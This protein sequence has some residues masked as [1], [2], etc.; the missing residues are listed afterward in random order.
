MHGIERKHREHLKEELIK[1][2]RLD[3]FDEEEIAEVFRD[4]ESLDKTIS[5]KTLALCQTLSHASSSLV[6]KTLKRIKNASRFLSLREMDRWITHAFDLL[7]HQGVE[8]FISFISRMDEETLW[9]F[10]MPKGLSLQEV[11]PVLETYLRGISGR[12]LKI[13]PDKESYTDTATLY[14]PHF[15]AKYDERD[16]N[17]LLYKLM[18]AFQWAQISL[19]TLTPDAET[20]RTFLKDS[21]LN[22]PDIETFFRQFPDKELAVDLYTIIEAV[23]LEPLLEKELPGLMREAYGLKRDFL[24]E[25]ISLFD[26]SEKAAFVEGLYQFYLKGDAGDPVPRAL[27]VAIEE[28]LPLKKGACV[29]ESMKILLRLYEMAN[30]LAG[31][32]QPRSYLSFLGV[33]KPEE[34]SL[35][36]K[37]ER[38]AH[39]KR[40]EGII[41]R[42]INMPEFTP[43]KPPSQRAVFRER[44]PDPAKEYLLIKGRIVELDRETKDLVEEMGGIPGSIMVKGAD[45]GGAGCP[46]TLTELVEEEDIFA[47]AD[48]G[49][50]YDEWD[51][52]RGGY[53][54]N[55]CTLFEHTIHPGHEPFVELTLKR[56]SGYVNTLRKKFELL[57]REPKIV[58]RQKDGDDIDIDATV[59]AFADIRAGLSPNENF[60]TK[61]DRQERNFAV[62]FLLDMSGSTKGWV[63]MAEKESLVLMAEALEALGDR[64]SIYG[65]SGMTRNRC[66]FYCVKGFEELYSDSVKRRISGIAPKDY[67][68]MGPP[69]R[70]SAKILRSIE[71]R[72]KLFITLSDGKPE[73]YDAYKGDYGVEDTRRALIE[74]KEQGIHSFCITIDR[75]ASSYLKYMYG[76]VNY[77]VIDDVK[78]LPNKITEIY[79]RLTT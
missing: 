78:K 12:E 52:K 46:I 49:I 62:L 32:Y 56:Y 2:L 55:W 39:K 75:E 1:N 57:K 54:K 15:L 5:Q 63:N 58:R 48:G 76:E 29:G 13:A 24:R 19:G 43:Q 73:D 18:V 74:A 25:R 69:I 65:F 38:L 53:K 79:R 42:V 33:I 70:H 72:T 11:A 51:Y 37:A 6:P 30:G 14:L 47:E 45:I 60:F 61:Y 59:E 4:L 7:D 10:L 26:L 34:V 40:L 27:G 31:S 50:K 44:L 68:R 16:K 21:E 77:V 71:A 20:L 67:T 35:H 64:Y 3:F 8:P 9:D 28:I 17:F 23:R 22:F 41:T 36:L 66:D